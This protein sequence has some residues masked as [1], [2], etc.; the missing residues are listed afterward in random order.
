MPRVERRDIEQEPRP[1]LWRY[2]TPLTVFGIAGGY[3]LNRAFSDGA[4]WLS[5]SLVCF[6]VELA[7][8]I[9]MVRAGRKFDA[10]R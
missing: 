2:A 10:S 5:L 6:A 4:V 7:F 9:A 3:A 8:G 1:I